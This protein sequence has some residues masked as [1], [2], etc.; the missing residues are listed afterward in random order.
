MQLFAKSV[1]EGCDL[2]VAW[3]SGIIELRCDVLVEVYIQVWRIRHRLL[4]S[5]VCCVCCMHVC[6]LYIC[7]CVCVN[8]L[9]GC[10]CTRACVCLY[11]CVFLYVCV[12]CLCAYVC[13]AWCVYVWWWG[14]GLSVLCFELMCR[15]MILPVLRALPA[16][17]MVDGLPRVSSPSIASCLG[18]SVKV[19]EETTLVSS[20][21]LGSFSTRLGSGNLSTKQFKNRQSKCWLTSLWRKGQS[22]VFELYESAPEYCTVG[23]SSPMTRTSSPDCRWP[24]SHTE[25]V[26]E[27][28]RDRR[29]V[30][31][32]I[33]RWLVEHIVSLINKFKVRENGQ[34][35][36]QA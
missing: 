16:E 14:G 27:S 15:L 35:A 7:V 9:C 25:S 22:K 21:I 3:Y 6:A 29:P 11:V 20:I 1:L 36:Y 34:T 30:D 33:F 19:K 10:G 32:A 4:V 31:H 26:L 17:T 13:G 28:R 5:C 2:S 12:A 23:S 24:D 18:P 8:L